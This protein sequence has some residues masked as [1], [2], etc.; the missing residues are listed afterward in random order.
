M[1]TVLILIPLCMMIV[2]A[3]SA[4][5]GAL[6][7]S[8]R[9]EFDSY[10]ERTRKIVQDAAASI[11]RARDL[12]VKA[13]EARR[14]TLERQGETAAVKAIQERIDAL[15]ASNSDEDLVLSVLSDEPPAPSEEPQ[16]PL[17]RNLEVV[18]IKP[19]QYRLIR[20]SLLINKQRY[21]PGLVKQ[22]YYRHKSQDAHSSGFVP[23][24]ELTEVA[25]PTTLVDQIDKWT[26][27]QE[28]NAVIQGYLLI[29]K[30]GE[31]SFNSISYYDRN[32]LY[33]GTLSEP[34]CGYRDGENRIATV[35]LPAGLV[36]I[37]SVGYVAAR[38]SCNVQ[39]V[40]PGEKDLTPIP[41]RLFFHRK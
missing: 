3:A 41:S 35:T 26:Y 36:P 29:E 33:V 21:Y 27:N 16:A 22:E 5:E 23:L 1:R 6:P 28:R 20:G 17:P 32:A 11:R 9:R 13:L 4:E 40:P 12:H 14:Q 31:Y 15:T 34:V 37:A 7:D 30:E 38:G 24:S 19:G 39:W 2:A 10:D 25:G 18:P 8:V